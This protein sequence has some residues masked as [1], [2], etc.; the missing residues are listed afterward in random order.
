MSISELGLVFCSVVISAL[1]LVAVPPVSPTKDGNK[2]L[3]STTEASNSGAVDLSALARD[4]IITKK[5]NGPTNE[6]IYGAVIESTNSTNATTHNATKSK[7]SD[8]KRNLNL[9][10]Q[11]KTLCSNSSNEAIGT[12]Q[13]DTHSGN[14]M[15]DEGICYDNSSRKTNIIIQNG[16]NSGNYGQR[17]I[18]TRWDIVIYVLLILKNTGFS[19]VYY[20]VNILITLDRFLEMK[21]NIRYPQFVSNRSVNIVLTLVWLSG[22]IF[23]AIIMYI[24][25]IDDAFDHISFSYL[26]FFSTMELVFLFTA[27]TTY[28]YILKE[29]VRMSSVFH[30]M[31]RKNQVDMLKTTTKRKKSKTKLSIVIGKRKNGFDGNVDYVDDNNM[32]DVCNSNHNQ[33]ITS[34]VKETAIMDQHNNGFYTINNSDIYGNICNKKQNS[35]T[36]NDEVGQVTD[37]S[38]GGDNQASN[39]DIHYNENK[40]NNNSNCDKSNNHNINITSNNVNNNKNNS[41]NCGKSNNHNISKNNSNNNSDIWK[42]NNNKNNKKNKHNKESVRITNYKVRSLFKRSSPLVMISLLVTSF[43]FFMMLPDIMNVVYYVKHRENKENPKPQP[44]SLVLSTY[45]LYT[46]AYASDALIYILLQKET[47]GIIRRKFFRN[48]GRRNGLTES[49]L[50]KYSK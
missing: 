43:I 11:G 12:I 48:R 10:V 1:L 49:N 38:G 8:E 42:I 34:R 3:T 41:N 36:K 40:N 13:N 47:R 15:Q 29:Y 39:C 23:A 32:K 35:N 16:T 18:H 45:I 28:T 31:P 17:H 6:I 26:Y 7:F 2:T 37:G 25:E 21:L 50:T 44:W 33:R 22:A 19:L 20:V 27:L 24:G 14:V 9:V 4:D 46:I 30:N 5:H